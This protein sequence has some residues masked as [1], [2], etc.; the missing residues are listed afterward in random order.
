MCGIAGIVG[1]APVDGAALKRMSSVI[2]HRGPD[3][4]GFFVDEGTGLAHRRLA[5]VDLSPAGHQPM[6]N[7]DGSLWIVYNG[8]VYNSRVIG[9]E[10]EGKGHVFR[11]T[12]DTE[13]ILHAYEQWGPECVRRFNGMWGFAIWDRRERALFASRDRFGVKPF[14]YHHRPGGPFVFSSEIKAILAAGLPARLEEAYAA[15]VLVTARLDDGPETMFAGVRQIEPAHNLTYRNGE[16]ALRRYWDL[17]CRGVL[18]EIDAE[19]AAEGLRELLSDA[20]RLRVISSDVQVGSCLSGGLD[21]STIVSL[22]SGLGGQPMATFSLEYGEPG[23]DESGW[24]RLVAGRFACEDRYIEPR[25]EDFFGV[26]EK[27]AWFQDEPAAGPGLYSQWHVMELAGPHVKVLLD[28]QGGDETMA[29]YRYYL[30]PYLRALASRAVRGDSAALGRFWSDVPTVAQTW[31]MSVPMALG[32]AFGGDQLRH[33]Y[34]KWRGIGFDGVLSPEIAENAAANPIERP[35]LP[36][37]GDPLNDRLLRDVTRD[38]IPS[39]LHYEDR[40]SMAFSIEAR[41]P[42]LDYRLIEY[43]MRLPG[44]QKV[45]D[46]QTKWLFREAMRGVTPPEILERR[47]KMGYKTPVAEWFRGPLAPVVREMLLS[48]EATSRGIVKPDEMARRLDGHESGR[49]DISWQIYR[50]LSLEQWF[51]T[52]IDRRDPALGPTTLSLPG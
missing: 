11:S 25:A 44:V 5:I 52:F 15:H 29:G 42:F 39:L 30:E 10:L 20:V 4:E 47:D 2:A 26:L 18:G 17:D 35:P 12:S 45:R 46:G 19:E 21:S 31:G 22:A 8:E 3:D 23:Y 41:T 48:S 1:D 7:E 14:Y 51:R 50:W 27:M 34:L 33:A 40:N 16:V 28:G 49:S 43:A 13:V 36:S 37:T 9:S 38:V 6:S 24:A 32:R